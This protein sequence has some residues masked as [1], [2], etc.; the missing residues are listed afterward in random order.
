MSLTVNNLNQYQYSPI[1]NANDLVSGSELENIAR[2]IFS[3]APT[4]QPASVVTNELPKINLNKLE[5]ANNSLRVFGPE[6]QL[7]AQNLEQI[8]TNKAGYNLNLSDKALTS[9]NAL[10]IQ[11]AKMQTSNISSQMEGKIYVPA[12]T[13]NYS[14]LKSVFATSNSPRT[15]EIGDMNKDRRGSNPFVVITKN[16]KQEEAKKSLNIFA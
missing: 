13:S 5:S 1:A 16:E 2:E 15:F 8:A 6:A 7:N 10:N 11:A 4:T 9:I 12:D 3:S 14:D